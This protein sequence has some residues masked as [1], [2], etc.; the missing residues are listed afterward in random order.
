MR[1]GRERN[2]RRTRNIVGRL[3]LAF[4]VVGMTLTAPLASTLPAAA[5]VNPAPPTAPV[6]LIFI[7]HSTGENWLADDHGGLGVALRDNNYFVSDTNYGWGPDGIGDTTDIGH[8][9]NW[10]RGP[11]SAD[12]L[13]ALYAESGQHPEDYSRLARPRR[14]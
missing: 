1:S 6:K 13:D 8:W 14:S 2:R 12:Y 9:W 7:H 10:F 11:S 4:I 5:A 3:V